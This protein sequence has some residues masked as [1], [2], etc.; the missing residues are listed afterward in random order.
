MKALIREFRH[1]LRALLKAPGFTMIAILTL[2][3]GIGANSTIFS[4][5]NST[6][7]NPIPGVA[8]AS[9]YVELTAG[10]AGDDA[11]I[12]YPD[13][14]DLRDRNHT[15]SSLIVYT[16]WS[17]DITGSAK[18]ERVW[19][20]FSSANYFDALDVHPILGRGFLPVEGTKPGGAPVVVI[21]DRLWQIHFGSDPSIIGKTIHINKRPYAVV[22]V[23]P[24]V[25]QGTQSGLRADMWIPV[26]MTQQFVSDN[27]LKDRSAHW[28]MTIGHLKTGV[29]REQAQSD[30]NILYN[31]I[32]KQFPDAHKDRESLILHPLWRAPFGANYYLR[33]ILLLLIAISGVV[34][35]LACANVANLLLVR[36]VGRR[37]EMAIRL[38]VGATRWRL[39]RQLL[40]ESLILGLSGGGVAMLLTTWS[41]GKLSDFVPPT[42]IPISMS[43]QTDRTVLLVTFVISLFTGL[44]FGVLP[45]LRAFQSRS[46]RRA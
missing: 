30:V 1:G 16:L 32:A 29:T 9:Q 17:V 5:I 33:T 20:L 27:I 28:L 44:I 46:R 13:Y 21:S 2:A 3:L 40:V 36:G 18:P 43:V 39:V 11:P 23:T 31:Q 22:G 25:F 14:M 42:E 41:A 10:P 19:A 35:L 38:S 37:R 8:H 24:A 15:L 45:A 26:M 6:L 7:L 34:L 12:S 4:W